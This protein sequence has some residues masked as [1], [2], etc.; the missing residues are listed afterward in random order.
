MVKQATPESLDYAYA[1]QL[2]HLWYLNNGMMLINGLAIWPFVQHNAFLTKM[3]WM[4][5]YIF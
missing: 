2:L 3:M 4:P 1:K 5:Y